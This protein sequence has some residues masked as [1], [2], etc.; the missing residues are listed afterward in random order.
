MPLI[1][2]KSEK[3]F[4]H[5]IKAEMGAGKPQKQSLA[6]AY[7]V[8]RAAAKKA[9]AKAKGGMV[10][11]T[12]ATSFEMDKAHF[13]HE[14]LEKAEMFAVESPVHHYPHMGDKHEMAEE[15]AH[16]EEHDENAKKRH[17][18]TSIFSK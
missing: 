1:H 4:E 11:E 7:A 15:Y 17:I 16:D 18:L 12:P 8:K 2:G 13:E 14:A 10:E 6:I 3:A 9:Q 5:N